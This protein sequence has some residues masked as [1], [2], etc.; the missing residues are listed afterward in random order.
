MEFLKRSLLLLVIFM[1][2]LCSSQGYVFYVGG[3]QGWSAN[4]SEDYN[5]WAER[6]RFQVNDTLVFKYEKGQNSV[7][8]VSR[9]DYYKCNVENPINKYTDGNTEF[10]F[11]RSGS[12]FFISGNADYCQKGQRL[13]VIVLA[14]R[15]ATQSPTPAVPGNPPLLSPPS[16]SPEGSPS[17]ASSP[18]GDGHS[19]A[20]AP[21]GSAPGLTRSVVWVL[22]VGFGV[23]V[24]LGN[25]VGLYI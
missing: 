3:K 1:A 11:D 5:Q 10:K 23:S 2:F 25:F 15:N 6:N 4:P 24:V 7:L 18:A 14:V 9:E 20:P 21:H 13:I 22:G 19:P 17:P 12:F 16:E 8:V